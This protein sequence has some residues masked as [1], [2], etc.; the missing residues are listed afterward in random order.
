MNRNASFSKGFT[1]V[2]LVVSIVVLGISVTTFLTLVLQTTRDSPDAMIQ[3]QAYAIAQSYMEE[4]LSQPFCDPDFSTDCRTDCTASTACTTCSL[5]EGSRNQ[6]DDVCD[7]N[8]LSNNGAEDFNGA[9]TGLSAYNVDV[10]VDDSGVTL[11]GLSSASGQV[12][13]I[14]VRVRHDTFTDLDATLKA[15]MANF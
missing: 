2:E 5:A 15:Y 3:E 14:D 1:L 11:N 8:G 9:I 12:V 13:R 10:T 4:I 7:F 6:F